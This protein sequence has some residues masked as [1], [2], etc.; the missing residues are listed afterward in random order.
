MI[1]TT[2]P[3]RLAAR[4]A[5]LATA[6]VRYAGIATATLRRPRKV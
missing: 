1:D 5:R 3:A 6:R 4:H 2:A